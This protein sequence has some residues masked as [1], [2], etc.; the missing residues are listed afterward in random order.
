MGAVVPA[1]VAGLSDRGGPTDLQPYDKIN[2]PIVWGVWA[3]LYAWLDKGTPMPSAPPIQRDPAAPDGIARDEYGNARGGL[4]TPW[5]DVPDA[6]YVA[7]ISAKNPLS[8]GMRRFDEAQMRALYGSRE[9]YVERCRTR[10]DAMVSQRWI[11]AVDAPL[12]KSSCK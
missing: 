9:A 12:M 7:R 6:R 1:G 8:G 3:N 5:V 2:A 11:Q 10:V 4:R